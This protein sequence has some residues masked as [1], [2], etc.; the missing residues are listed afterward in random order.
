MAANFGKTYLMN[1]NINQLTSVIRDPEFAMKLRI[2]MKSENVTATKV[3][4]RFHHGMTFASWGEKITIE[5]TPVDTNTTHVSIHS[6]CGMPTHVVDW[7]KNKSVVSNIYDYLEANVGK[8]KMKKVRS[9]AYRR[10]CHKCGAELAKAADFCSRCG[11]K[12]KRK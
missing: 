11:A 2:A 8:Y 5:L 10:E 4:Y 3:W 9:T 12:A 6:E 1:V 7:G